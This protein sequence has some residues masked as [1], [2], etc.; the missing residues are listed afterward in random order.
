M[1]VGAVSAFYRK[2]TRNECASVAGQ[3]QATNPN[4]ELHQD[5]TV[6]SYILPSSPTSADNGQAFLRKWSFRNSMLR[7]LRRALIFSY[8][9]PLSYVFVQEFC[10]F[11]SRIRALQESRLYSEGLDVGPMFQECDNGNLLICA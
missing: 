9:W 11:V 2:R 5:Q 10:S 6:Q 8:R 4:R 7:L 1:P 3:S